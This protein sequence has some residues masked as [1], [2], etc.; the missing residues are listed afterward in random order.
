MGEGNSPNLSELGAWGIL[1]GSFAAL[2]ANFVSKIFY[3]FHN[4]MN[5]VIYAYN[6]SSNEFLPPFLPMHT[7][8]LFGC[9]VTSYCVC[10]RQ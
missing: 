1:V 8:C 2:G 7:I 10:D 4:L 9:D 6:H 3:F 5:K